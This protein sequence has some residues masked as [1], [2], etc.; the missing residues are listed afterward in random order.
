MLHKKKNKVVNKTMKEDFFVTVSDAY[1]IE[2][3]MLI[4]VP[5]AVLAHNVVMDND[6][7]KN[8]AHKASLAILNHGKIIDYEQQRLTVG[9]QVIMAA[10]K[11]ADAVIEELG[12]GDVAA[13]VLEAVRVGGEVL[14][15]AKATGF[16]VDAMDFESMPP[17]CRYCI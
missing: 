17:P 2:Q 11:A 9:R 10:R 6:G 8:A 13:A 14:I 1:G 3:T 12:N 4:W 16:V 5:L 15:K 7:S